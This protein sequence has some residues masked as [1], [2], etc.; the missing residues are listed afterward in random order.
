MSG[1][2]SSA[3]ALE[4]QLPRAAV[5]V[6]DSGSLGRIVP[7]WES[8][9]AHALE[10]NPF[11]EHWVL[12]PALEAYAHGE[13]ACVAVFLHDRLAGLF[14]FE[15]LKRYRGLPLK[16]LRSWRHRHC[17]L[18][19]PLLRAEGA[20]DCL[21]ALFRWA[22]EQRLDAL[23]LDYV[24]ADG[25]LQLALLE[26]LELEDLPAL[27]MDR[28]ARALLRRESDAQTY[29][30]RSLSA[31]YR[32]QLRRLG[33]RLAE[34]GRV[35]QVELAPDGDVAQWTRQFMD[36]EASGWK[37]SHG[38]ALAC[39]KEDGRFASQVFAEAHR[40]GRL[41][42]LGLDVDGKPASRLCGF[43]AGE[44]SFYFKTA[45]DEALERF[46]PGVL[47]ELDLI[48][49]V[50]ALPH[51]QWTDS[52]TAPGN[53]LMKRLWKDARAIQRVAIGLTLPGRL[54][55]SLLPLLRTLKKEAQAAAAKASR[56]GNYRLRGG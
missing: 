52:F 33:R 30:A 4:T 48:A 32:K 10:P 8:L 22:R 55:V 56:A 45:Y 25:P 29:L 12:R 37:G 36:L 27:A 20:A 34:H 18:G 7:Q 35:E 44:G 53:A 42:A 41:I 50:H 40:R 13:V 2:S 3:R 6:F 26:A 14:P 1:G 38:T 15:R 21:R 17:L 5:E 19:T 49:K 9:A 47:L 16:A 54:A 31:Q 28:F 46:S 11:Y 51:I 24:A 43:V 23:E 39:R